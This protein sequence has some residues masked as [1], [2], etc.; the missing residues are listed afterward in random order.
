M[1]IKSISPDILD[2]LKQT[3]PEI[4]F[5]EQKGASCDGGDGAL[6]HPR[7][8]YTIGDEGYVECQYCDRAFVY[9]PKQGLPA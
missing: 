2:R 7:V 1:A 6:G 5:V 3:A 9:A 4:L 8:Y